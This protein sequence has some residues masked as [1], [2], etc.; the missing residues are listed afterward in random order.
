MRPLILGAGAVVSEYNEAALRSLGWDESAF[1]ADP[2][3]AA[4]ASVQAAGSRASLRAC[5]FQAVLDDPS[6]LR[7]VDAAVV[8]LPNRLHA[9]ATHL[10]LERGLH[11]LCEKPLATSSEACYCLGRA[12]ARAQRTLSVGMVRRLLPSLVMLRRAL[13]QQL[14]GSLT[15]IDIQ[16]G[17]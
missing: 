15:A 2:S 7:Q 11:V 10:A 12:A 6:V 5:G 13:Q 3:T 16:D 14:I 8:A 4:L 17:E 1:I 9:E